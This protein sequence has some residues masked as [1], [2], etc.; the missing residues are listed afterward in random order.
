MAV[1]KD[2]GFWPY[3]V[4][5]FAAYLVL[6]EIGNRTPPEFA[7]NVLALKAVVPLALILHYFIRLGAYPE[8]RGYGWRPAEVGLDILVGVAGAV[9]WMAPYL[10][11]PTLQPDTES[12]FDPNQLG[13]ELAWFTL[14]LRGFAYS[15]S[16]PFVE[17]LF[18]R[19]WLLRYVDV[20]DRRGDFRKVPISRYTRRSFIVVVIAFTVSH[21]PWEWPVSLAWIVLTQ[22]YFYRRGHLM[23]LVIVH[24]SSNLTIFLAALLSGSSWPGREGGLTSLWFFV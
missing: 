2:H 14:G 19:S 24:A 11:F 20:F 7:G 1:R 5:Y 15:I 9:L 12:A 6:V 10:V 16:T 13:P 17:E 18:V 4:P 23:A 21:V 8:L 3:L 22:W